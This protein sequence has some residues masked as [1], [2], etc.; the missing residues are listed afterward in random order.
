M[1]MAQAREGLAMMHAG[2]ATLAAASVDSL[3]ATELL[4]VGDGVETVTR[5]LPTQFHRLLARLQAQSTA[6]ELGA[7]SW[8]EVLANRWR[9][10]SAEAGRRLALAAV[11]GPRRSLTGE[12]LS[13]VLPATAAAAAAGLITA[14]HVDIIRKSMAKLPGFVDAATAAAIEV[15]RVRGAGKV[16]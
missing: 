8:R 1:S 12:A 3:T 11:L 9:I 6:R 7:K 15:V 2:Y 16:G 14:E 4:A 13:P 10:S 5:Q